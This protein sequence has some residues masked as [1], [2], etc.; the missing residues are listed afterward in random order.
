MSSLTSLPVGGISYVIQKIK[1]ERDSTIGTAELRLYNNDNLVL[2]RTISA[3]KGVV[4][5]TTTIRVTDFVK[6][7]LLST[8][9]EY[10]TK[11]PLSSTVRYNPNEIDEAIEEARKILQNQ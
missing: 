9:L 11:T 3:Y 2:S 6:G 4:E 5:E 1:F 10:T 7:L 8:S